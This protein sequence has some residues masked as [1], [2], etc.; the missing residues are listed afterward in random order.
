MRED[1]LIPSDQ[2]VLPFRRRLD[3]V[4]REASGGM[5][6]EYVLQDPV[7]GSYWRLT[8]E[9][10]CVLECLRERISLRELRDQL[11]K[12]FPQRI[13]SMSEVRLLV[14]S[15]AERRLLQ[16]VRSGAAAGNHPPLSIA[17]LRRVLQCLLFCRLPGFH[18]ARF[19]TLFE[20]PVRWLMTPAMLSVTGVLL[21]AGWG[22]LLGDLEI[23][24]TEV[25]TASQ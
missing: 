11:A 20:R 25:S 19:L 16:S 24:V 3:L 1:N 7:A 2:R 21:L 22:I 6:S 15:L 23:L 4:L 18:P 9:Q 5:A 12:R 13:P 17:L 14:T 10:F 8:P